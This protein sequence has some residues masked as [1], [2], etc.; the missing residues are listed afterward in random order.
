M[1]AAEYELFELAK[2]IDEEGGSLLITRGKWLATIG[3]LTYE[4]TRLDASQF[5]TAWSCLH[6]GLNS[7]LIRSTEAIAAKDRQG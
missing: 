7:A 5:R 4:G 6:E 1:A 2:L 3:K